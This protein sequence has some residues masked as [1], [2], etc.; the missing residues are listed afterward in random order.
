NDH[1]Q[2]ATSMHA[3]GDGS[4]IVAVKSGAIYRYDRTLDNFCKLYDFAGRDCLLYNFM[5]LP[6]N[7][8]AVCTSNGLYLCGKEGRIEKL[9]LDGK[10]VRAVCA[11]G[12]G[13]FY[14]GTDHGAYHVEAC[15]DGFRSS[16]IKGTEGVNVRSIIMA[17]GSL[18]I[19]SFS[20]G[21]MVMD[22]SDGR[23]RRL[24]GY[25]PNLP[26]NVLVK[27]GD[28]SLLAGV[29]GA[30]VFHI[31]TAD[32]SL[33]R[34]YR[35]GD[36]GE[37][38]LSGN[39]VTDVHIDSHNGL[40]IATS[41]NGVNYIP[42]TSHTVTLVK[43]H[44]GREESLVSDYVNV[45]F[46][47]I[48]G[49]LWFGTDKGVSRYDPKSKR[50]WRYLQ[51]SDYVASVVLSIGE[52]SRGRILV[53]TY[54]DGLSVIDKHSGEVSRLPLLAPGSAQGVGTDYVFVG[55][56]TPDGYIWTGG[57]NGPM[58]R[59]DIAGNSYSHY[60]VDCIAATAVDNGGTILFGGNKGIGRYDREHDRFSWTSDFD[61]IRIH[62]PVRAVAVDTM[63]DVLWVGTQGEGLV[64]YDRR[65][66]QARRYTKADG[67]SGNTIY[68]LVL[69]HDGNL[70]VCTETDLYR[71][72][73][74]D[75]RLAR[76]T[77]YLDSDRGVFNAGGLGI[78]RSGQI[79]LGSAEGCYI[80]SPPGKRDCEITCD[81]HFTD[82][83]MNDRSVVP[84]ENGSPLK[85]NID[86]CDRI[87]LK[88]NQNS[89]GIGFAAID[90]ANPQRNGFEYELQ[91]YYRQPN[92]A[93]AV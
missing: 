64:R 54:G 90:F 52:D 60:D 47:D 27:C 71:I 18:Y 70:W 21:L 93:V 16:F 81:V 53:G 86:L 26:V 17:G 36:S 75:G 11:D 78:T 51:R 80:F 43:S 56:G 9:A 48:E 69:D 12:K 19:G 72:D 85:M 14:A 88:H 22:P 6:D 34:H 46:E 91:G 73:G 44:A 58:T 63:A 35:D 41:H 25:I 62:Y 49:N 89:F 33:L 37:T 3:A 82:F 39:T 68:G 55:C 59:Y 40:W 50:W 92:H 2:S 30:G 5:V 31:N 20:R 66:R 38:D 45:A 13:G 15:G 32:G 10:F 28:D 76:F 84:G 42:S 61:S 77:Y 23:V 74:A 87:E 79:M 29:D 57:I 8:L 83:I 67:L 65:L 7:R 24:S 4:L 1:I